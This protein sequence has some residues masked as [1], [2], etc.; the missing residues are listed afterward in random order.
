MLHSK[1]S[2]RLLDKFESILNIGDDHIDIKKRIFPAS[3]FSP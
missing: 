2:V 3:E 1:K